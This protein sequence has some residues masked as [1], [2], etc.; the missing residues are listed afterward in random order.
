MR[1]ITDA[2]DIHGKVIKQDMTRRKLYGEESSQESNYSDRDEILQELFGVRRGKVET[3]PS[4]IETETT[5]EDAA[6]LADHRKK[7]AEWR[8]HLG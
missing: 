3:V 5:D 4:K 8:K 1:V 6:F 7:E 2:P